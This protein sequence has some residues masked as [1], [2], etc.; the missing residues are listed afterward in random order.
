MTT[1]YNFPP[2]VP[3]D[4]KVYALTSRFA[5]GISRS[6][7]TNGI[8][9]P[10]GRW[11]MDLAWARLKNASGSLWYAWFVDALQGGAAVFQVNL[12]RHVETVTPEA[13]G[14]TDLTALPWSS[15]A[16]SPTFSDGTGFAFQPT[17]TV[18]AVALAG[19]ARVSVDTGDYGQVLKPG[20]LIGFGDGVNRVMD[21]EWTGSV[22]DITLRLPLRSSLAPDDPMRFW[23]RM[24]VQA[25]PS[26]VDTF[27]ALHDF[28]QFT[29]PGAITF[30][31]YEA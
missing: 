8:P 20:H 31:E 4:I 2:I 23:P 9:E 11:A 1:I 17:A 29:R 14:L 3:R 7:K 26:S 16:A 28:G 13:L 10:N 18:T 12:W 30:E 21:I 5:P 6:G 15:G 27:R 22:A 19:T 25:A 24:L